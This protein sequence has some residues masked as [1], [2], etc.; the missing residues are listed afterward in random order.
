MVVLR[1]F[2]PA[3]P[4]WESLT[5]SASTTPLCGRSRRNSTS[6]RSGSRAGTFPTDHNALDV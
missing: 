1:L 2:L 4:Y 3:L 5:N 6:R